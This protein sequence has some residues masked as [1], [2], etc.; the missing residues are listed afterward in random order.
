MYYVKLRC[1]F[2]LIN[3]KIAL[4]EKKEQLQIKRA[5]W[6]EKTV[7]IVYLYGEFL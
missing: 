2:E 1:E 5:Y 4:W 3:K 6:P 7:L